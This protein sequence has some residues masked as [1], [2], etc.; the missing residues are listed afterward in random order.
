MNELLHADCGGRWVEEGSVATC[1]RCGHVQLVSLC[2]GFGVVSA[3]M[4]S[5]GEVKD[6]TEDE[7]DAELAKGRE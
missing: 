2:A 3:V 5:P 7:I 4:F 6:V 1:D